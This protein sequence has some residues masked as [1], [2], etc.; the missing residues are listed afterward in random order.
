MRTSTI[1]KTILA[2]VASFSLSACAQN[3]PSPFEPG[4]YETPAQILPDTM[5][6]AA[7]RNLPAP[8]REVTVAVYE[9]PDLTGQNKPNPNFAE[10][11]R[12]VTQ[13]ADAILVDVLSA[14]GNGKWFNVVE[15]RGLS[16]VLRERQLIQATR[17]QFQGEAAEPLPAMTFAGVLIEGGVVSYES[18]LRTGGIGAR[19][20]GIGANTQYQED[21]VTVNLRLVAVNSGRVI[22]SVTSTKQ[23]YSTLV[24]ASVFRYVSTD[25]LLEIDA[26]YTRNSPPQFALREAIELGVFA[27]IMEGKEAGVWR[28][29]N[30]SASSDA[31][32]LYKQRSGDGMQRPPTVESA[33][34]ISETE[35]K[36]ELL[37]GYQVEVTPQEYGLSLHPE[38]VEDYKRYS[39]WATSVP[40]SYSGYV[41]N[42]SPEE[43]QATSVRHFKPELTSSLEYLE[44]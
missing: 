36:E 28:F 13:G 12:A 26:G 32:Q 24:Q 8:S 18:N 9:F 39:E 43:S 40:R 2:I 7:V 37:A 10:Y 15:R 30:P 25:S 16:N 21:Y 6:S 44:I 14:A 31:V 33:S 1:S 11:S 42:K 3:L 19:Y 38:T 20:L 35:T 29:K 17:Q 23:I 34:I 4:E 5:T 27:L 22:L 41:L